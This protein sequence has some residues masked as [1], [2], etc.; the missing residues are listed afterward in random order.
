[1]TDFVT[2]PSTKPNPYTN[3]GRGG[4]G[5]SPYQYA[6]SYEYDSRVYPETR[7]VEGREHRVAKDEKGEEVHL[8]FHFQRCYI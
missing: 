3:L 1:M 4:F 7:V 8:I 2:R 6:T 5:S